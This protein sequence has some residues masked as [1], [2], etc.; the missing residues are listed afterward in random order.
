MKWALELGQYDLL[1]RPSMEIKVQASAD[2]KAEFTPGLG[3][4]T[5]RPKFEHALAEPTLF[6]KDFWRLHIDGSPNYK[7]SKAGLV[8]IQSL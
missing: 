8:L 1:Y 2:L 7:G 6:D 5:T 4:A 3:E